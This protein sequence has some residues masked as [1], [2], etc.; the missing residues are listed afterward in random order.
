MVEKYAVIPEMRAKVRAQKRSTVHGLTMM[1]R[2]PA[3][4]AE[5]IAAHDEVIVAHQ[6]A[7]TRH[8][9]AAVAELDPAQRAELDG[10]IAARRSTY[11]DETAKFVAEIETAAPSTT[12]SAKALR[13]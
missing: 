7:R 9:D 1:A 11:A 6:V 13:A 4:A 3:V 5:I 2:V 8:Y 12:G 10:L